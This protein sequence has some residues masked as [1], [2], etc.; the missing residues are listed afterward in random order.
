MNRLIPIDILFIISNYMNDNDLYSFL[1]SINVKKE[2]EFFWKQRGEIKFKKD[3]FHN[4]FF[5]LLN[6]KKY[7]KIKQLKYLENFINEAKKINSIIRWNEEE[8]INGDQIYTLQKLYLDH[9]EIIKLPKEIGQ[10]TNLK[11]LILNYNNLEEV[12]KE[13]GQLLHLEMIDLAVNNLK[14]LPV[15]LFTLKKVSF[16][17]LNYNLLTF[18]PK[19]IGQLE[20][21]HKFY[22]FRNYIY[23]IPDEIKNL[24]N[25]L[26]LSID[27][28]SKLPDKM[29]PNIEIHKN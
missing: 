11:R 26:F 10:M 24:S 22:L 14:Q 2:N 12:P 27:E 17:N 16:L 6:K 25:L 5:G 13:I 19:E 28:Y 29:S 9:T 8:R 3:F 23:V 21:L 15:E 7:N 4:S 18:L 1:L 20:N